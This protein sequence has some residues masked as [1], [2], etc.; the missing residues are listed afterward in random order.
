MDKISNKIIN[1]ITNAMENWRL[2][3]IAVSQTIAEVKIQRDIF[4]KVLPLLFVIAMMTLNHVLRK[5]TVGG[6]GAPFFKIPEK[7]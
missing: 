1:I 5:C 2:E 7:H 6:G 4:Q 3:L